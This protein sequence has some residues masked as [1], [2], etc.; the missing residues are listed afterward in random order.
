MREAS[1]TLP[2]KRNEKIKVKR[3]DKVEKICGA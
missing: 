1:E 2:P 3:I